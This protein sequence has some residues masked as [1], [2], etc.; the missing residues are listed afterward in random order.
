MHFRVLVDQVGCAEFEF[1]NIQLS[2][3]DFLRDAADLLLPLQEPQ[4][5]ALLGVFDIALN[6]FLLAV[7]LF[8]PQVA[9]GGNDGRKKQHHSGQRGQHGDPV[10]AVGC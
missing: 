1:R 7:H 8:E 10:L 6:G 5:Q 3:T 9:Q 2:G 4:A